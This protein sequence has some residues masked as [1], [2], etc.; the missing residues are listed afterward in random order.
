MTSLKFDVR[1]MDKV[2]R[3][4]RKLGSDMP[5]TVQLIAQGVGQEI[6]NELQVYPAPPMSSSYRRTGRLKRTWNVKKYGR[7][8]AMVG[9]PTPYA[10][11]VQSKEQ[12]AWMHRERWQTDAEVVDKVEQS[13]TVEQVADKVIGRKLRMAGLE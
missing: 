4:L 8:A 1:D 12:Q 2:L 9:N 13:G 10:P 6:K 3:G 11:Y 5:R 7:T